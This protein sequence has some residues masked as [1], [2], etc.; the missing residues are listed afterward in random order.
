MGEVGA[1]VTYQLPRPEPSFFTFL[2]S[3]SAKPFL[4]KKRGTVSEGRIVP[5]AM[6]LWSRSLALWDRVTTGKLVSIPYQ[7]M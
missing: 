4:P 6:P 5:S 3:T 1:T 7:I 2:G